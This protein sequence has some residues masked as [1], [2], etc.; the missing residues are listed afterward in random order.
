MKTLQEFKK[1]GRFQTREDF[2]KRLTLVYPLH[3]KCTDIVVYDEG[4][5]IQCLKDHTFYI[6]IHDIKGEITT[7]VQHQSLDLVESILWDR[8]IKKNIQETNES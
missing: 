5:Y 7:K 6:C 1:S 3:D 2:E 8:H 4:A